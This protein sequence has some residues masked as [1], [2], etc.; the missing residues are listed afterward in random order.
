MP[1]T[2]YHEGH[3]VLGLRN[4]PGGMFQG[5]GRHFEGSCGRQVLGLS[6]GMG[7]R[8]EPESRPFLDKFGPKNL[9]G[10]GRKI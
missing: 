2:K 8:I 3:S 6:G 5:G 1:F 4:S 9:E 7:E 10:K